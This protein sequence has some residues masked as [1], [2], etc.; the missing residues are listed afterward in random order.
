MSDDEAKLMKR[1]SSLRSIDAIAEHDDPW[2]P[3]CCTLVA[4]APHFNRDNIVDIA[5]SQFPRLAAQITM[6]REMERTRRILIAVSGICLAVGAAL[7]VF[8]PN[9]KEGVAY[10]VAAILA[11]LPLGAIGIQ[12][13]RIRS[14]GIEIEGGMNDTGR[15]GAAKRRTKRDRS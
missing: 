15:S 7:L 10:A 11:I 4:M 13:F 8:A 6:H 14:I 1:E 2:G 9:G 3:D 5:N 12:E